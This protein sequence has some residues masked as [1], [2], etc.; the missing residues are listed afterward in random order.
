MI[1][2]NICRLKGVIIL[3]IKFI[4]GMGKVF[5][6]SKGF[7]DESFSESEFV[8]G[9]TANKF[10]Q[11]MSN[12]IPKNSKISCF[13]EGEGR[14]A[15]YL[16]T[17]GHEIV[18]YDQSTVGLE[19][20]H[21]LAAQHDVTVETVAKDLTKDV[22]AREQ[23]D[24]AIMVYGHVPRKDQSFFIEQM[25]DSVR[26]GGYVFFEV[27]SID[28]LDYKTGGPGSVEMLYDPQDIL[29]WIE[30]HDCLHFYY[31]EAERYEGN[32][33]TGLGHVIQVALRKQ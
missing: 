28:Q 21:A 5:Y 20:A 2:Y 14:N 1:T 18:A 30:P 31:G 6:M 3:S 17:L 23:Y 10:I 7:W 22:V 24:G 26:P 9:E 32:R 8:Y 29:K 27:Y 12:Y 19:K 33:H 11:K 13:A 4:K 25:I 15:V 16:A